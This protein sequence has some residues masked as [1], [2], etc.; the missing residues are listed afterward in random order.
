[1]AKEYNLNRPAEGESASGNLA[2][3]FGTILKEKFG[4]YTGL[5][6]CGMVIASTH[7]PP[8]KAKSGKVWERVE[9]TISDG[10]TTFKHLSM[11][12]C[13]EGSAG[14]LK[15]IPLFTSV[16]ISINSANTQQG[17]VPEVMGD[18]VIV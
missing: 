9:S 7:T 15:P 6:A 10:K 16:R 5:T 1:M 14:V 17:G 13:A 12:E 3:A 2:S 18:L 11:S 8:K 4:E